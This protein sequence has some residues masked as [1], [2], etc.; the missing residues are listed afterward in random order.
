MLNKW[1]NK[2]TIATLLERLP[3]IGIVGVVGYRLFQ[4]WRTIGAV[5]VVL[6]EHDE[7]L[8]VEHVFHPKYPWGMP[9]GWM[10]RRENPDETVRREVLEETGLH[11]TVIAPLLIEHALSLGQH[12]DI[13]YLC[14]VD[15]PVGEITLSSELLS[16]RWVSLHEPT[17]LMHFHGRAL[18][19]A[20]NW[21]AQAASS[22]S[23]PI[24]VTAVTAVTEY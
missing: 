23:S 5:G 1:L 14:R 18:R 20:Q 12:V 7:M 3:W 9:G 17:P 11:V 2:T 10:G 19:A 22:V 8:L 21:L 6:N 24:A 16:F 13:A 4:P 15:G